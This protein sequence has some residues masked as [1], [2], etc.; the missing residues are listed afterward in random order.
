MCV[1]EEVHVETRSPYRY[2]VKMGRDGQCWEA[3]SVGCFISFLLACPP[4]NSSLSLSTFFYFSILWKTSVTVKIL[5]CCNDPLLSNAG[6]RPLHHES[7]NY[8]LWSSST[9]SNTLGFFTRLSR[10]KTGH[11]CFVIIQ[12]L[13]VY[14][15]VSLFRN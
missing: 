11:N 3:F 10:E 14:Q 15:S 12:N 4:V 2:R 13:Q 7:K 1:R 9:L 5:V 6:N 8:P